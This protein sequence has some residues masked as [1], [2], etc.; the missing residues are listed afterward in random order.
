MVKISYTLE[1]LLEET[2]FKKHSLRHYMKELGIV[3][4]GTA[5]KNASYP[6]EVRDKLVFYSILRTKAP[7]MTLPD[8]KSMF[9][10]TPANTIAREDWNV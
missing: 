4:Q 8:V 1:Q 9:E 5:G 2:G 3:N 6:K 7:R 10:A